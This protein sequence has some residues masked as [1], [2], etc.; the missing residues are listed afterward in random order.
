MAQSFAV[1]RCCPECPFRMESRLGK[2]PPERYLQLAD[3]VRPGGWPGAV[4][5]CHMTPE[6]QERA[7]AG[8][9]LVC[10]ADSNRIRMAII[11]ERLDMSK[12]ETNGELYPTY[13]AMAVANGCDPDAPEFDGLPETNGKVTEV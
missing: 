2:F 8:M 9:L 13:R 4:F 12:I 3:T 7:C 5:A 11:T 6:G 10:G 1:T